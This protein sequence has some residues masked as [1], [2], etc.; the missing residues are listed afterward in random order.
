MKILAETLRSYTIHWPKADKDALEKRLKGVGTE[1]DVLQVYKMFW[2]HEIEAM[3][4]SEDKNILPYIDKYVPAP[5]KLEWWW[6]NWYGNQM[7]MLDADTKFAVDE[8][9]K[10]HA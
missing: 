2:P 8:Y 10:E 9:D 6:N 5:E 3:L 1:I 7:F 4:R